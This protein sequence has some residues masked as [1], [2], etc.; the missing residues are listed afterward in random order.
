MTTDN[1]LKK[2]K[3]E[4][5]LVLNLSEEQL[6]ERLA[7]ELGGD[8]A[9]PSFEDV[10]ASYLKIKSNAQDKICRD[11][12]VYKACNDPATHDRI[13]LVIVLADLIGGKGAFTFAGLL[14]K[15]G[16]ATICRPIWAA[17]A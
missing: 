17:R 16:I 10:K 6:Y 8:Q 2:K 14:M 15:E 4:A 12:R 5:K 3:E 1:E 13:M 9:F 11:D 7:D